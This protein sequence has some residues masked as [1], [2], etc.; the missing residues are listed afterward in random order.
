MSKPKVTRRRPAKP[1]RAK[2]AD[3]EPRRVGGQPGNHNAVT[4]GLYARHYAP[5]ELQALAEASQN[6]D[7][8]I[9]LTR[10]ATRRILALLDEAQ[11]PEEKLALLNAMT[12]ASMRV[13]SLFKTQKFLAGESDGLTDALAQALAEVAEESKLS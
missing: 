5:E 12:Q 1:S 10:V 13:A 11:T 9:E 8:E 4:H 2:P 7:G 3:P 6:L